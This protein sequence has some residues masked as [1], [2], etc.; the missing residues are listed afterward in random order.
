MLTTAVAT[1]ATAATGSRGDAERRH[2]IDPVHGD[3]G[4]RIGRSL[5]DVGGVDLRSRRC[6]S[7]VSPSAA[8]SWDESAQLMSAQLMSVQDIEFQD[9]SAQDMLAQD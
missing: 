6:R 7:T 9:M 2:R 4:R 1:G 8:S 5:R 3:G